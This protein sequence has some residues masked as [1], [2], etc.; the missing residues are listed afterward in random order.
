M[1]VHRAIQLRP[2]LLLFSMGPD[3]KSTLDSDLPA[4]LALDATAPLF[5]HG[6]GAPGCL[7]LQGVEFGVSPKCIVGT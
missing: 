5:C 6:P 7:R 2:V 4:G 3:A 1:Q